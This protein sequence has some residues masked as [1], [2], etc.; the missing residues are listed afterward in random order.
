MVDCSY[1]WS[2]HPTEI[3]PDNDITGIGVS[4]HITLLSAQL[5]IRNCQVTISYV[6]NAGIVVAIIMVHYLV[7]YDPELNPFRAG[8]NTKLQSSNLRQ[9]TQSTE[10]FLGG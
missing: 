10:S 1:N 2:H 4:L 9:P 8:G 7:T 5:L 3:E 6:A